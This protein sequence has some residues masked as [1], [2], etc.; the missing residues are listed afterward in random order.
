MHDTERRQYA[1][2][3]HIVRQLREIGERREHQRTDADLDQRDQVWRRTVE[4]L[5]DDRGQCVEERRPQ[6]QQNA[7]DMLRA[8]VAR[9]WLGLHDQ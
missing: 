3:S 1:P 8:D 9:I 6:G 5:R 4:F 7:A 2:C